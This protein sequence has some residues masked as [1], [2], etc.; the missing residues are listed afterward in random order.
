MST[1]EREA[2]S[3]AAASQALSG[4]NH[5]AWRWPGDGRCKRGRRP[6]K[7]RRDGV[8]TRRAEAADLYAN[9]FANKLEADE[10]EHQRDRGLQILETVHRLRNHC[11]EGRGGAPKRVRVG[12]AD[13][14][15][16]PGCE[17]DDQRVGERTYDTCAR[18]HAQKRVHAL[19]RARG[20]ALSPV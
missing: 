18:A 16:T 12:E 14:T 5:G 17:A 8:T 15:R 20:M 10:A 6:N 2:A 3:Q 19:A 13:A 9:E 11:G 4:G 1:C 7:R